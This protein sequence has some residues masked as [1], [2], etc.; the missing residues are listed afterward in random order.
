VLSHRG[1]DVAQRDIRVVPQTRSALFSSA[2]RRSISFNQPHQMPCDFTEAVHIV[3]V[4][5]LLIEPGD[6]T[7]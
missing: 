1:G 4:H 5:F 2:G 7:T 6:N 3:G